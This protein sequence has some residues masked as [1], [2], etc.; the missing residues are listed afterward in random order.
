MYMKQ[1]RIEAPLPLIAKALFHTIGASSY[2]YFCT[3]LHRPES[4]RV[5]LI[6]I[7]AQDTDGEPEGNQQRRNGLYTVID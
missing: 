2:L 6:I 1:G 5:I 7:T 4:T 3:P